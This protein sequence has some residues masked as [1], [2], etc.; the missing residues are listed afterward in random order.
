MAVDVTTPKVFT[1]GHNPQPQHTALPGFV[2]GG[3][4]ANLIDC[5]SIGTAIAASYEAE[6]R[7]PGTAPQITFVTATP[8]VK[9][10]HPTP[11][12]TEL[13]LRAHV[14]ELHEKKAIVAC[15]VYHST[16]HQNPAQELDNRCHIS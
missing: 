10:L 4:I 11:I 15:S 6:A 2:Y 12:D 16:T 1:S 7:E 13:V 3:L 14:K 9:Y 8:K 5:H